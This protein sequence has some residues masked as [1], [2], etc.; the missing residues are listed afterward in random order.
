M[1]VDVTSLWGSRFLLNCCLIEKKKPTVYILYFFQF[2]E[3]TGQ[4]IPIKN[5]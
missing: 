4:K 5:S 1:S 3:N 2:T